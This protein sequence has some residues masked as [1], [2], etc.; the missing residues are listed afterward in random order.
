[1]VIDAKVYNLSR[2]KD[3]HPGGLSVLIDDEVGMI[4]FHM[5][6]TIVILMES[7]PQ[8]AKM[9]QR[10]FTGC[11]V[12]KSWSDHNTNASRLALLQANSL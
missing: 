4:A 10:H 7:V 3:L 8:L 6:C 5:L 11:I 12:M 1:V 2:F 9:L